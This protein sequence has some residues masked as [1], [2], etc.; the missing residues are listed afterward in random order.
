MRNPGRRSDYVVIGGVAA[1]P[2]AAATLARRLPGTSITL[3]HREKILSYATCGFPFFASGELSAFE[4]LLQT[5]YGVTRDAVFF[6]QTKGV[7]AVPFSE[8]LRI[9]R[10][11]K[12][13]TVKELESGEVHEHGYDRLVLATG[14]NPN[15][16]LIPIPE[17]DSVRSF[18]R[19]G[20]VIDF[21]QK[22]ERGEVADV[23]IIGGGFVGIELCEAVKE[24]WGINVKLFEKQPQLLP[25]LLDPEMAAI[26]QRALVA[27]G[28]EVTVAAE[29][30][31]ITLGD[32]GKP[33]VHLQGQRPID[34]DYV[35]L[36]MGVQPEVTLARE[37]GL[38]IGKTGAI[39]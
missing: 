9:D 35:F 29:V 7:S 5:G 39:L 20:D 22:A 1:G 30:E 6:E 32:Q 36:C 33:V 38:D 2:K 15:K 4:Q 18:T 12:S 28:I 14:S 16:P 19:P 10:D 37:C 21:R 25:Y 8:V 24:M 13:V 31:K 26:L 17:C 11:K 3:F 23:V 34:T 27:N